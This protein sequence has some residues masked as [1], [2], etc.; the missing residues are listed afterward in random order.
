MI[1]AAVTGTTVDSELQATLIVV[2]S[3]RI[4]VRPGETTN[5]L[6]RLIFTALVRFKFVADDQI[7]SIYGV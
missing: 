4:R 2:Y 1:E 5:S 3:G 6:F 7:I